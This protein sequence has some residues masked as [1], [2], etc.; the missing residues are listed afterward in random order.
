MELKLRNTTPTPHYF[1]KKSRI[2]GFT[3][4]NWLMLL[5]VVL[6]T[7]GSIRIIF[8]KPQNY[9]AP[10]TGPHIY[11]MTTTN[12]ITLAFKKLSCLNFPSF[13]FIFAQFKKIFDM[14]INL[15]I[16]TFW[17]LVYSHLYTLDCWLHNT[18]EKQLFSIYPPKEHK[19]SND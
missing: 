10:R 1:Y 8:W 9:I 5:L 16:R 14:K 2:S 11:T 6:L 12:S 15:T 17:Y 13:R 19:R 18:K 7:H 4:L 3:Q